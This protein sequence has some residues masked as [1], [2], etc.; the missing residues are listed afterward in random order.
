MN[1]AKICIR[2]Y[3][4]G[5]GGGRLPSKR[6]LSR[7]VGSIDWKVSISMLIS[8]GSGR[9]LKHLEAKI[10]AFGLEEVEEFQVDHEP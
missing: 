7:G 8:G 10:F 1:D 3:C 6:R 9:F 2:L 5:G 4:S